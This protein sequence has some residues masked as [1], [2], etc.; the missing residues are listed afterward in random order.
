L[1]WLL[2][3]ITVSTFLAGAFAQQSAKTSIVTGGTREAATKTRNEKGQPLTLGTS[4]A[5]PSF[6]LRCHQI[7]GKPM[8]TNCAPQAGVT[9]T[10]MPKKNAGDKKAWA[11][12]LLGKLTSV[13]TL[14]ARYVHLNRVSD[15]TWC[16]SAVKQQMKSDGTLF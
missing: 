15:K 6:R 2:L 4:A 13:F 9:I 10:P 14:Q 16:Q 12:H 7:S 3:P 5:C 11:A 8:K 1:R